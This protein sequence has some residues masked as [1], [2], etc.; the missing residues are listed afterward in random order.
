M[1]N[2]I[3]TSLTESEKILNGLYQEIHRSGF[4]PDNVFLLLTALLRRDFPAKRGE[5]LEVSRRRF[6]KIVTTKY[7]NGLSMSS[8][9]LLKIVNNHKHPH[10]GKDKKLTSDMAWMRERMN[11]LVPGKARDGGNRGSTREERKVRGVI[12]D[13]SHGRSVRGVLRRLRRDRPDLADRVAAGKMSANAAAIE[14]GF[15][16]KYTPQEQIIRLWDKLTTREK[17][18]LRKLLV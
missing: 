9:D 2:V 15:R 12:H 8:E 16:K 11:V 14:A 10:E 18:K 5:N 3:S 7:P 6:E 1:T 17:T 4:T 13:S